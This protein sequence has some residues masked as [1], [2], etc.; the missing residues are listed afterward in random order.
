M[1]RNNAHILLNLYRFL[2]GFP[3]EALRMIL[4]RPTV[5]WVVSDAVNAPIS[6]PA[7]VY[8]FTVFKRKITFRSG[9]TLHAPSDNNNR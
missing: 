9:S 8:I 1:H 6:C 4:G 2:T 5:K 7:F 3:T